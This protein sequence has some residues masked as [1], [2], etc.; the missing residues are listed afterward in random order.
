MEEQRIEHG[1]G[2]TQ[3]TPAA[4]MRAKNGRPKGFDGTKSRQPS[5]LA[6]AFKKH[7]LDWKQDF[8]DA[9][10]ANNKERIALWLRLLPYLIT[11]SHRAKVKKWKGRASKAAL[12]ALE[13]MEQDTDA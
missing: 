8:A 1:G 9:I 2:V 10:R 6:I 12:I 4:L 13:A 3:V 11:T 5:A 7:G